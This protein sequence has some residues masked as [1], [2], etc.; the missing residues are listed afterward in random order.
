MTL[1]PT[2]NLKR[3]LLGA[4]AVL[5]LAALAGL[6]GASVGHTWGYRTAKAEGD[7]ALAKLQAT[8]AEARAA[9]AEE[10][11]QGL[12]RE[13]NRNNQLAQQLTDERR[14]HATEKQS[15]LKRIANVTTVYVPVPGA[16]PEPL[17][18]SVFTVGFV[19][20]YNAALGIG[21]GSDLSAAAGGDA[22]AGADTSPGAG[23]AAGAGLRG[24]FADL[25]DSGLVQADILAHIA[26]YGERCR[27]FESQ[28][29]RLL[30]RLPG[31]VHGHR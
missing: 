22:A 5:G 12:A 28:L 9:V 31:A 26:D 27:N 15:L 29:N 25:Q 17:P 6:A 13:V 8:R 18:R 3:R 14:K 10:T 11:A 7:A 30:D 23:Q 4:I 20:E 16:A 2:S 24:Q 21:R 1:T 19:R